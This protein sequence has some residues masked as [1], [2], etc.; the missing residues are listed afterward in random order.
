MYLAGEGN[1]ECEFFLRCCFEPT[2]LGY[3]KAEKIEVSLL[4]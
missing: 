1:E 4:V 3:G 2:D